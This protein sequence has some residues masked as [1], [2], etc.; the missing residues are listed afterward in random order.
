MIW[1]ISGLFVISLA[2]AWYSMRD[3]DVPK[4]IQRVLPQKTKEGRIVFFKDKVEHY[5]SDSSP[6]S[7]V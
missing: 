6:S 3:F 1:I 7:P 2:W 4:E 5:S